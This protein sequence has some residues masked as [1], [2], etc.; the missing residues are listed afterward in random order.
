M[1]GQAEGRRAGA[2]PFGGELTAAV[3]GVVTGGERVAGW[4]CGP[5]A[6]VLA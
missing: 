2:T 1:S 3:T 5:R 6:G 4:L